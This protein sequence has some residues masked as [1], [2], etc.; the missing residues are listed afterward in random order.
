MRASTGAYLLRMSLG[1]RASACR[2]YVS[3]WADKRYVFENR[4]AT[5]L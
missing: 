5:E 1:G 4:V 3:S 2:L